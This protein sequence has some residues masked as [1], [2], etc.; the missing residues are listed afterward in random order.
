[1]DLTSGVAVVVLVLIGGG[2]LAGAWTV[3]QDERE[4][5][6]NAVE[7]EGTVL[8]TGIDREETVD[9]R[10]PDNDGQYESEEREVEFVPSVRYRYTY[11]G[12]TYESDSVYPLSRPGFDSRGGAENFTSRYPEGETVTVYVNG[13]APSESFLVRQESGG[14]LL[15]FAGVFAGVFWLVALAIGYRSVRAE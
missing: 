9:R 5:L 14:P 11:Q 13:E 3:Q 10:D 15:L 1:M 12:E 8:S 2:V 7:H 4:R 6:E